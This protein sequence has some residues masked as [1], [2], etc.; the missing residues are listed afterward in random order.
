MKT[1]SGLSL[2]RTD[3]DDLLQLAKIAAEG[4]RRQP[5]PRQNPV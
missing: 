5:E 3:R 2:A 1:R 4:A